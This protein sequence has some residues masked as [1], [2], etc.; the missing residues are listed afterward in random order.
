[1]EMSD[2]SGMR[3]TIALLLFASTANADDVPPPQADCPSGSAGET[4]HHGQYCAPFRCR[5]DDTCT[6]R[7]YVP[8]GRVCKP[9]AFCVETRHY[10]SHRGHEGD[11]E[12]FHGPCDA[13]GACATGECVRESFCVDAD[14]ALEPAPNV[15]MMSSSSSGSEN[16]EESGCAAGGRTAGWMCLVLATAIVA[17]RRSA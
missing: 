12:V 8:E 9:A 5:T 3:L 6:S 15:T 16:D 10:R 14:D 17:R 11:Y 13:S 1:M 7:R 4:D 2:A